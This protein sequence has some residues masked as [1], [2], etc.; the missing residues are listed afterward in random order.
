[1]SLQESADTLLGD[2]AAAQRRGVLPRPAQVLGPDLP[3]QHG[4]G[5]HRPA[6]SYFWLDQSNGIAGVYLT[7][8]LPFADK[9]SLPLFYDFET[10]V[11]RSLN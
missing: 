3:D 11:Y 9:K 10:A 1:M 8:I 4:A 2:A 5:P 7:Q 6:N